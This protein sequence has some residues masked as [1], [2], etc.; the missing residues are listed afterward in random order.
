MIIQDR[1]LILRTWPLRETSRIIALQTCANGKVRLVARGVRGPRSRAG[2]SLEPGNE[3]DL[4]F[5][6]KPGRDLGQLRESTLVK[7]WLAQSPRLDSMAAGW[8]CLEL[9]DRVVPDGAPGGGLLDIAWEVLRQLRES[10]HRE[11]SVLHFYAFELQ[12]LDQLGLRPQL[13]ECRLCQQSVAGPAWLDIEAA[14]VCC[15]ACQLAGSH[16]LR[17]T[18]PAVAL[19]GQLLLH[20]WEAR[21][22][23]SAASVRR[24]VGLALHRLL[25]THVDRYRYPRSLDL[26]KST[27][28]SP[29]AGESA[30][31]PGAAATPERLP[32][33]RRI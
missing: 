23:E 9:L 7:A 31:R 21:G 11:E 27:M 28:E 12:L 5:S 3:V 4:V 33:S 14:A 24:L 18:G 10:R 16:Y 1:G 30:G 17:L 2:A 22:L 32:A 26:L 25:T 15:A 13:V 8:A 29:S 20:P 19:L 6:L